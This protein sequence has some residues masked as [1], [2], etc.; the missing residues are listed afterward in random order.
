MRTPFFYYKFL[1]FSHFYGSARLI[2]GR[3]TAGMVRS[4]NGQPRPTMMNFVF[5]C[6]L[7]QLAIY[8]TA[9]P[10]ATRSLGK[11]PI[12]KWVFH[13]RVYRY[14]TCNQEDYVSS[15]DTNVRLET[16]AVVYQPWYS[17]GRWEQNRCAKKKSYLDTDAAT[18]CRCC[19]I[20]PINTRRRDTLW[21]LIA[22]KCPS[23]KLWRGGAGR[24]R[25]VDFMKKMELGIKKIRGQEF[26]PKKPQ[27]TR[28]EANNRLSIER[29]TTS[30]LTYIN[31]AA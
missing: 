2:S 5:A 10:A 8:V 30:A 20:D 13:K 18:P 19:I 1:L 17:R 16:W 9:M 28:A 12:D 31:G 22:R 21:L 7:F 11:H 4:T 15:T 25:Y 3:F 23:R 14:F 26:E 24:R 6:L 27:L 29:V